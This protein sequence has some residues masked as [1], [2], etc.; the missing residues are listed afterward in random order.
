MTA[1]ARTVPLT[2]DDVVDAAL[3]IVE[4]YGVE[5]LTMR[6]LAD[7]I[8][9]AVTAIY[10]HVGNRDVL[11][12]LLVDRLMADMGSVHP[13]GRT[14][15]GRIR[16]IAEEWRAK[17]LAH[18]HLI[19]LAHERAK[20]PMMF[21]PI[22]AAL[23]AELARLG[24]HGH[25]AALAVRT[26]QCHVVASVLLERAGGRSPVQDVTDPAAWSETADDPELVAGLSGPP[27]YVA[28]FDYG[29]DALLATLPR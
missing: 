5:A 27:D 29:L 20:T 7:E 11:I 12:D 16:S 13:R 23:A 15:R 24:L 9:A 22:Q 17:L 10:H 19:G 18:P 28:V 26:L 2:Q 14:P 25:K 1:P 8:G 6:R 4:E 3:R 21:A